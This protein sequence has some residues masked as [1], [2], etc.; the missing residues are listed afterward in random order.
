MSSC[1]PQSGL[2]H[3]MAGRGGGSMTDSTIASLR[4]EALRNGSY[5][6]P[7]KP[8]ARSSARPDRSDGRRRARMF[9]FSH[10]ATQP[11]SHLARVVF[12][13]GLAA[14]LVIGW[15]NRD[16]D[17][18]VPDNGLGYWLGIAGASLMLLLLLYPLRKRMGA[19]RGLGS[20]S[21][22]FRM[23]M[24]LGLAGPTL[25]LFHSKFSFGSLNSNVALVAMLTVAISGIVGRY[26]Y[27]KIH[28]GLYG[29][30][31]EVRQ[32][33][34]DIEIMRHALGDDL[35]VGDRI[36]AQL[37]AFAERTLAMPRGLLAT[38][39]GIP[40]LTVRAHLVSR[41]VLRDVRRTIADEAKRCGWSRR[42]REQRFCAIAELVTLYVAAVKKAATFAFYER[43]FRFWHV[44]HLPL[45]IILIVAASI[46]VVAAHLF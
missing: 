41:R 15:L 31:A 25:V 37:N 32:I 46:H 6:A 23:H 33:L 45:F 17:Y 7:L 3:R 35:A 11:W 20:V 8:Q 5:S 18:L 43:V 27:G 22:W 14:V 16:Q 2:R 4:S 34:A 39:Y 38:C 1:G 42:A 40:V 36:V 21:V 13:A 12:G 44:L 24:V 26:L 28:L 9:R 29:R 19:L 30:K 10:Y